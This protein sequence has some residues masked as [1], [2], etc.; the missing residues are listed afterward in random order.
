MCGECVIY[1]GHLFLKMKYVEL[2]ELE[3]YKIVDI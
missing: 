2:L 1:L 3:Q